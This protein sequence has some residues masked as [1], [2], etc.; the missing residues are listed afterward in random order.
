MQIGSPDNKM[1]E[2]KDIKDNTLKK[3]Q[4]EGNKMNT[5]VLLYIA[6]FLGGGITGWEVRHHTFPKQETSVQGGQ[7]VDKELVNNSVVD[8]FCTAE[9]IDKYGKGA[10]R[11][12]NCYRNQR[13]GNQS[14]TTNSLICEPISNFVNKTDMQE[15]CKKFAEYSVSIV[16]Q[17]LIKDAEDAKRENLDIAIAPV[18][19]Q[20]TYAED[21]ESCLDFFD[22]RI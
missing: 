16:V 9:F 14:E 22:K 8:V 21:Y 15:H 3:F 7:D 6:L 10:C 18:N 4:K 1:S 17:N 11:E 2:T 13:S 5:T 20:S 19:V 12:A